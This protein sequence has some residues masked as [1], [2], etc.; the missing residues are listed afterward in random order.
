MYGVNDVLV[1]CG[2]YMGIRLS[3]FDKLIWMFRHNDWIEL[4]YSC[5]T[6]GLDCRVPTN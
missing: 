2:M 3:Q 5:T 1:I 4:P 6:M